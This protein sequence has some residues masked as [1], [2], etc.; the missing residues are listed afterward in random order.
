MIVHMIVQGIYFSIAIIII[1]KC[2]W[3]CASMS[4]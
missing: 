4:P 2:I 1:I 3:L